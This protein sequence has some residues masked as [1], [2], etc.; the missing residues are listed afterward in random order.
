MEVRKI[1]LKSCR[2]ARGYRSSQVA[3]MLGIT[4]SAMSKLERGENAPRVSTAIKLCV[5]Y[6]CTF[7]QL[8]EGENWDK[9]HVDIS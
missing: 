3:D 4:R 9:S 6:D 8:A 5:I 1:S 7:E 2:E